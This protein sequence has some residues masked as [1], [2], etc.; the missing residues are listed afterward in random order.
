MSIVIPAGAGGDPSSTNE[1]Q[2]LSYD[3]NNTLTLTPT[4]SGSPNTVTINDGDK[5]K[6]NEIQTLNFDPTTNKISLSAPPGSTAP[7]STIT[8]DDNDKSAT[9][10]LQNLVFDSL[11]RT[12]SIVPA[13]TT[14]TGSIKLG[15]SPPGNNEFP[16]NC[17]HTDY[18]VLLGASY[19]VLPGKTLFITAA[20]ETIKLQTNF[21]LVEHPNSP[22]MPMLPSGT[23]ISNCYCTAYST[24][25]C[26]DW[27]PIIVDFNEPILANGYVIPAGKVFVIKSGLATNFGRMDVSLDNGSN[28]S[29]MVIALSPYEAASRAPTFPAGSRIRP[30]FNNKFAITG[31]LFSN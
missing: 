27:I 17:G 15:V 23:T 7:V 13:P 10:E 29:T 25:T 11:S 4:A 20:G 18:L 26:N 19:T 31:Y 8:L 24:T 21:G 14:G 30:S 28:W 16:L 2:T 3:G 9:N 22:A 12:I 5:D 1:L 6:F